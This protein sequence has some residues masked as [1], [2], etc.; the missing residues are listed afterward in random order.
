[1]P[2]LIAFMQKEKFDGV[3]HLASLFLVNHQPENV[4][5]LIES[6]VLFGTALLE[7]SVKSETPWFINTG[8][9][10]QH[11]LDKTYCPVNLYAATKQAFEDIAQYYMETSSIN[12]VTVKLFATFGPDDTRSKVFNLWSKI[13]QTQEKLDMSPG[14]QIIDMSY[15]DNIVDGYMRLI[16]L[17]SKDGKRKLLGQ[18]FTIQSDKRVSLRKLAEMFEKISKTKLNI[19]WGGRPYGQREVMIPWKK[20]KHIPGYKPSV[21]LEEGIKRTL[22][23]AHKQGARNKGR[24]K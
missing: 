5:D 13:S 15:I 11:Y 4:T 17:I 23:Q 22:E 7:A 18:A 6:N 10:W 20:G 21:K 19:N 24:K 2:A 12:F 9:F 14:N 1:M 16:S 8:T 3:I